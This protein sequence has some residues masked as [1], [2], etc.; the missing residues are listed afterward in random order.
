MKKTL[1]LMLMA[2]MSIAFTVQAQITLPKT[3][4]FGND[5]VHW[6]LN[7]GTG[8]ADKTIDELGL[9]GKADGS[10]LNM[11]AITAAAYTFSD[12][13][14]GANRLQ[15]NGS[16]YT[17]STGFVTLPTQRYLYFDVAGKADVTVWFRSGS[18]S[19]SRTV[20]VT[21]GAAVL[22]QATTDAAGTGVIFTAHKTTAGTER[23]YIYGDSACN[24]YKITV[25]G[26]TMATGSSAK[27]A[28]KIFASGSEV[29]VSGITAPTRVSVYSI[30]GTLVKN[31]DSKSDVSFHLSS[32]V[33]LINTQSDKGINAQKVVVK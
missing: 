12:G 16:G 32:G 11:G 14:A 4:D 1:L 3:W 2:V 15:L 5:T 31:M 8:V 6:P 23:I 18:N 21:N 22:A 9:Y 28:T 19:S 13:Y 33:Y 24:I 29:Y 10:I 25:N 26:A 30:N 27:N 20:Y 7:S 17:S